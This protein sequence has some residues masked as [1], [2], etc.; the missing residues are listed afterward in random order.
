MQRGIDAEGIAADIAQFEEERDY[1]FKTA[2][3]KKSLTEGLP[4]E[5]QQYTYAEPSELSNILSGSGG[6]MKL[7]DKIFGTSGTTG[8]E[9]LGGLS[10]SQQNDVIE[11]ITKLLNPKN[12]VINKE[13]VSDLG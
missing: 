6:L 1:P 13:D 5:T 4:L 3:Y 10:E 8:E 9:A 11:L 7:Y 2:Q 12:T